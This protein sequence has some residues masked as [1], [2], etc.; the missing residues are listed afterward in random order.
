MPVATF[1][2]VREVRKTVQSNDPISCGGPLQDACVWS[3]VSSAPWITITTPMPRAGDN[4]VDGRIRM[5]RVTLRPRITLETGADDALARDLV[6]KAHD[7]CFIANSVA[8]PVDVE[9]T[10]TFAEAAAAT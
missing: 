4:P 7:G 1:L 8:T 6:E 2:L 5:S 9:P 10:F 3:A